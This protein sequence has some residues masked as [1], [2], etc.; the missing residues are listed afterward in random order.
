MRVVGYVR[1]SADPSA[2]RSAFE[3][4]EVL[5]R[6][7]VEHGHSLVAV[8]QDARTPGEAL[9]R[10]GYLGLL[11]VVASGAVDGVLIAGLAALS[12]DQIVQEIML[13]DLRS[14]GVRVI[15]ADPADTAL[16]DAGEE[17]GPARMLIRDVLQRV[18]EHARSL[19]AHRLDAP[20]ILPDGDVMIHI[21]E[22]DH[23]EAAGSAVPE[24]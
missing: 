14:R 19:G 11:G 2:G 21:V 3:Q 9:G 16:L 12:S 5:R 24:T 10:D 13:W 1:E 23:A 18:G 22:A 8:C 15:S 6:H 4:Q 7:A 17:P 20:T